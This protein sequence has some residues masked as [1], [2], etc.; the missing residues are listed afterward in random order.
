MTVQLD[1]KHEDPERDAAKRRQEEK[2]L[3][4]ALEDTFPSSDP[5][6]IV[7]PTPSPEDDDKTKDKTRRRSHG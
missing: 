2:E 6:A 5:P 4:E 1:R 3:D 7:Q